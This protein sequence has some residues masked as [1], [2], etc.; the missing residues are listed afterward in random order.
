MI[1]S[2]WDRRQWLLYASLFSNRGLVRS[3]PD[4]FGILLERRR[5]RRKATQ[6]TK[7]TRSVDPFAQ[8]HR[9]PQCTVLQ[10]QSVFLPSACRIPRAYICILKPLMWRLGASCSLIHG[11]WSVSRSDHGFHIIS[12]YEFS[13]MSLLWVVS[14]FLR[15]FTDDH[16]GVHRANNFVSRGSMFSDFHLVWEKKFFKCSVSCSPSWPQLCY[17]ARVGFELL[18]VPSDGTTGMC[19]LL[20]C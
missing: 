5:K 4:S 3:M 17:V 16:D 9:L 20:P 6:R 10:M 2:L 7:S 13:P 19:W 15:F 12:I 18:I 11:P 14:F 8:L 1:C